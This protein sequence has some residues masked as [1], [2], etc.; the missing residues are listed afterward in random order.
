MVGVDEGESEGTGEGPPVNTPASDR[1]KELLTNT[2]LAE[3]AH[4]TQIETLPD[5][6]EGSTKFATLSAVTP[7]GSPW[8]YPT[9]LFEQYPSVNAALDA[10]IT[11][12]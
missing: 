1:E 10:S 12:S 7:Y 4:P 5:P 2:V 8:E 11:N 3:V 6:P 9:R